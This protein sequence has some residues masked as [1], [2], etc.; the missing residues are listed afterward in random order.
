MVSDPMAEAEFLLAV[1][2]TA[3]VVTVFG[4]VLFAVFHAITLWPR[5]KT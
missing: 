2:Y 3:G 5:S 1:L 4:G